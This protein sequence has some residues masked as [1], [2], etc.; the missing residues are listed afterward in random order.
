MQKKYHV[1]A[2]NTSHNTKYDE[3]ENETSSTEPDSYTSSE[4]SDDTQQPLN[5][6]EDNDYMIFDSTYMDESAAFDNIEDLLVMLMDVQQSTL[7]HKCDEK[8][9]SCTGRNKYTY[10][11]NYLEIIPK[12]Q[13]VRKNKELKALP[14]NYI[15]IHED[16]ERDLECID[17]SQT[18]SDKIM[19]AIPKTYASVC[20][21]TNAANKKNNSS[22][23]MQTFRKT[24]LDDVSIRVMDGSTG[25]IS[26]VSPRTLVEMLVVKPPLRFS[27]SIGFLSTKT[28]TVKSNPPKK[29]IQKKRK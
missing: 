17:L 11:V 1:I 10:D 2:Q 12:D 19:K 3:N 7:T 23:R 4:P 16:G 26:I 20:R 24:M 9:N 29:T 18:T 22:Y 6:Y 14:L 27:Y 21:L 15:Y 28:V 25:V 8:C 5:E 13:K